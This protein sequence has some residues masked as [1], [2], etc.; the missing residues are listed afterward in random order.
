[1]AKKESQNVTTGVGVFAYPY[2]NPNNIGQFNSLNEEERD[3]LS[4]YEW[5]V[6]LLVSNE[7]AQAFIDTCAEFKTR[8]A[9]P[10]KDL[11]LPYTVISEEDIEKY[12]VL[13]IETIIPSDLN[14]RIKAKT[15][16]HRVTLE[17][18]YIKN[19]PVNLIDRSGNPFTYPDNCEIG[20]GTTGR[21][22]GSLGF[23]DKGTGGM[24]FFLRSVQIKE[25]VTYQFSSDNFTALDEDKEEEDQIIL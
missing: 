19:S 20:H 3:N 11:R 15:R 22:S 5:K 6:D 18:D 2:I 8:H 23:Y 24:S 21:V 14:I 13:G 9:N 12:C 1:M 25:L 17:G 7:S 16:S 4:L 10:K